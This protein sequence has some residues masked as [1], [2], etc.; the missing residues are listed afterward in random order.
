MPRYYVHQESNWHHGRWHTS[1]LVR[2][3]EQEDVVVGRH[4]SLTAAEADARNRNGLSQT[5]AL[6]GTP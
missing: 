3:S 5:I 1:I 6:E 4:H 2:D